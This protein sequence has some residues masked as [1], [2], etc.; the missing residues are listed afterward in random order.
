MFNSYPKIST[1]APEF[2]NGK[3]FNKSL[4]PDEAE[5]YGAVILAANMTNVTY[6]S[7][8]RMTPF[9]VNP[10]SLGIETAGGVMTVL[11]PRNS[12]LQKK[13]L[14]ECW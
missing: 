9:D 12:I 11:I 8:Y 3:K 2:F 5:V 14:L 13:L 10:F 4:N 6:G 7:I 1:N